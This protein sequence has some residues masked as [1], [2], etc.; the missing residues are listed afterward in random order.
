[1]QYH[2]R[3]DLEALA[4]QIIQCYKSLPCFA[5]QK[6]YH[7]DP[8]VL[9]CDLCGLKLDHYRLSA[10]DTV[11]GLTADME[12]EVEV[13]TDDGTIFPYRLDGNTILVASSLRASPEKRGRYHFTILHE[14]AH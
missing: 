2:S 5:G 13:Q 9:A 8:I 6:I 1:M 14:A 7:I 11:L 10:D 12:I 3:A 4:N